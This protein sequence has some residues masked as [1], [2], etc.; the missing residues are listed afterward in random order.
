MTKSNRIA[1]LLS[2]SALSLGVGAQAQANTVQ[3]LTIDQPTRVNNIALKCTGVGLNDRKRAQPIGY[4][5]K[6]EAVG[7]YGQYLANEDVTL[8]SGAGAKLLDVTCNAPLVMIK[9]DPGRYSADVQVPG[10]GVKDVRFAVSDHGVR[11]VY[12]RFPRK[13]A[14]R[15]GHVMQSN[16]KGSENESRKQS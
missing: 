4:S 7:G 10:A 14:G 16:D 3:S 15:E 6:L 13:M 9:L 11:D 2:A 12:V 1:I 8:R 5:V